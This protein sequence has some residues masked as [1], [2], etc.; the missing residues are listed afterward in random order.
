MNA[1]SGRAFTLKSVLKLL[2]RKRWS[3][4]RKRKCPI[5]QS[6]YQ[7]SGFPNSED[8][9]WSEMGC[10]VFLSVQRERVRRMNYLLMYLITPASIFSGSRV[11]QLNFVIYVTHKILL[12]GNQLSSSLLV[13]VHD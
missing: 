1:Y 5:V 7:V 10:L 12:C 8:L 2:P 9:C 3:M 13:E 4:S 11:V 6:G